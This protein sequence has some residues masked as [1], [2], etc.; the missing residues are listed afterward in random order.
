LVVLA[1]FVVL[2]GCN[3]IRDFTGAWRGER[4]G[5]SPALRLGPGEIV[6]L[7]IDVI[8]NHGIRG[9]I[10]I[11]GLVSETQITSLEGAEADALANLSFPGNPLRV[12]LAFAPVPD[13]DAVVLIGLYDD[14]RLDVRVLRGG[15]K[16]LYAI[17]A[18]QRA[19]L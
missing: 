6:T 14:E 4:V 16:P 7:D 9:R 11:P 10:A 8:D 2:L 5:T 3:D 12:F 13:G 17:F 19:T 1:A 18:L 15:T